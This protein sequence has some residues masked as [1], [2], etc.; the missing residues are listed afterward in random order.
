MAALRAKLPVT[1]AGDADYY[2]T[3][4]SVGSKAFGPNINGAPAYV[5][6]T[7]RY[8]V[9]DEVIDRDVSDTLSVIVKTPEGMRY[10]AE[11][12]RQEHANRN[13][14]IM[15]AFRSGLPVT[16]CGNEEHYITGVAVGALLADAAPSLILFG[17]KLTG[18]HTGLLARIID[19]DTL[20]DIRYVLRASDGTHY[21]AQMNTTKHASRHQM[22]MTAIA[23][24]LPVTIAAD[25]DSRIT[26]VAVGLPHA[27]SP[28]FHCQATRFVSTE[29]GSVARMMDSDA[30]GPDTRYV[31]ATRDGNEW[32]VPASGRNQPGRDE[33]LR[34]ALTSAL[35]VTVNGGEAGDTRQKAGS[36][37]VQHS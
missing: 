31:L 11:I 6:S 26:G 24:N 5:S 14:L 30:L 36:L 37:V 33:L 34:I 20:D 1:V 25:A 7:P 19:S 28:T 9:I 2:L 27:G 4:L 16:L 10:G 15:A 8:G 18:M 21:C 32:C 23:M 13:H 22:L 12:D 35:Q 17:A 3:A 29:T